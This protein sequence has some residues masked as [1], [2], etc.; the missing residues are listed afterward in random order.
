MDNIEFRLAEGKDVCDLKK[1][2][3]EAFKDDHNYIDFYFN[4]SNRI[5]N[6]YIATNNGNISSM[7]SAIEINYNR[8]SAT[9]KGIYIYAVATFEKYRGLRHMTKL[10]DYV[11]KQTKRANYDFLML[12]PQT[13][14]LFTMYEN[15]NFKKFTY[16]EYMTLSNT[17]EENK[18]SIKEDFCNIDISDYFSKRQRFLQNKN[19]ITFVK[20]GQDYL[21]NEIILTENRTV[22]F[23]NMDIYILYYISNDDVYIR[24]IIGSTL[25]DKSM[26]V[27]K[28]YFNNYRNLHIKCNRHMK[29]NGVTNCYS[30]FKPLK[31]IGFDGDIYANL[32]LD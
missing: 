24:E 11:E 28:N 15:I 27:L 13:E 3:K 21:V 2:W 25:N 12:V 20:N 5:A 29:M 16:L 17:N 8:E 32:M 1:L 23:K 7:M 26:T 14:S 19:T 31:N 4:N 10:M 22:Y 9:Y 18:K 30:M 6:I